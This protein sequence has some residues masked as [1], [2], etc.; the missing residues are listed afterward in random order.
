MLI[1]GLTGGIG[2]GKSEVARILKQ[3][4]AEIINAD[5]IGHE[6]YSSTSDAWRKVLDEFGKD[7]LQSNGEIDRNKLGAIVFSDA[8]KRAK[9]N[10]ITHPEIAL[11]I[12]EN[13]KSYR[14]S[15]VPVV[16]IEAALLIDAGWDSMV[17]EVWIT[18]SPAE[19]V[20]QRILIR[21]GLSVSDVLKR[22]NSQISA[23]KPIN[24]ATVMINNSGEVAALERS[25][26]SI[27][28]TRIKGGGKTT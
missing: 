13:I 18:D 24:Q 25:I 20:I 6:V 9:L 17:D 10:S 14:A 16:V 26:K 28:S 12:N 23:N 5:I 8:R 7:I 22:I 21:D 2:T 27:W 11:V 19:T 3:L 15:G 1:I 4:G